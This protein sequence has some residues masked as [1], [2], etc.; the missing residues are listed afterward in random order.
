MIVSKCYKVHQ[1][2]SKRQVSAGGSG[3]SISEIFERNSNCSIRNH[4]QTGNVFVLGWITNTSYDHELRENTMRQ[5][6]SRK[7]IRLEKKYQS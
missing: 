6:G 7:V 1:T 4:Q 3:F 2:I 5:H